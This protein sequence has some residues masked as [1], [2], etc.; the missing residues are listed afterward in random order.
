MRLTLAQA[1]RVAL[2][3]QGFD[4][5]RPTGPVTARH[6][7]GVLDRLGVVQ[8]DSVNVLSRSHYLP[9]FSRLGTYDR[10]LLDRLRDAPPYRMV[11]Y[12]AHEASLIPP[13]SWPLLEARRQRA[14]E[15]GWGGMIAA[16]REHPQLTARVREAVV[17][18]GPLTAR[19]VESVLEVERPTDRLEWGWNWSLVKRTLEFLFW[20]GD[21]TSAGRTAS[22]ERRYAGLRHVAP[23]TEPLRSQWL[24]PARRPELDDAADALVRIAARAHGIGTARCLGDYF[25]LRPPSYLP[26]VARLVASGELVAVDVP[27]WKGPTYLWHEARVPRRVDAR[28]LLSPFDSL[29]W[30]RRRLQDLFG[31][32]YRLEIY[33]PA[34]QRVDGYYVLPFLLGDRLVG[35]V[36]L[37]A[38]RSTGRLLVQSTRWEPD[39]PGGARQELRAELE[40]LAAWLGLDEGVADP[41]GGQSGAAARSSVSRS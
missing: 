35:R 20:A 14:W 1:R 41:G 24:D 37:K 2:V 15:E 25:R 30:E 16:A 6:L 18:H 5:P 10:A 27:G 17:A 4:R 36:D 28:A 34:A 9:F 40:E 39:P 3:A 7:T 21:I 31:F 12:W 38:D 33:V 13:A 29:V 23:R 11:E 26:A 32:F 8:I 19:E 22:F